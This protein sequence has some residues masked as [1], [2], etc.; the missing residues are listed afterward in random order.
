MP[1]ESF[2]TVGTSPANLIANPIKPDW[3]LDGK[4]VA[5]LELLSSSADGTASTYI[6][7]CTAGR[8]NWFYSFDETFHIL[9][10]G[11]TLKYPSGACHRVAAG[12]TVFFPVGSSAEWTVDAYVRKLAFCRTPVPAYLT[13]ARQ[14]ARTLKRAVRGNS[15]KDGGS[16]LL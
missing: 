8:F 16:G 11:V 10:G 2:I 1:T 6:W 14:V 3:I 5:R 4:P 13:L 15:A 7:D 9:E 12:D